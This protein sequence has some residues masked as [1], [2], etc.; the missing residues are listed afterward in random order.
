VDGLL[1][2]TAGTYES[3]FRLRYRAP[4]ILLGAEHYSTPVDIWSI[5]CIFAEMASSKPLFPGD[6][7][8]D[9]LFRIFRV[10]GTPNDHV[11]PGVSRLPN[12]KSEFPQWH[13]QRLER[14]VPELAPSDANGGP[15][16]CDLMAQMLTYAPAMRVTC[17]K[18][19]EHPFFQ[20]PRLD[21][22][23]FAAS[24]HALG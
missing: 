10:R 9:E 23:Q 6:S 2:E 24:T 22:L 16:A 14:A 8:I 21:K 17:R 7:E 3:D 5:G 4:E 18:A 11:W 13:P 20:P 12:Y 15:A 1:G 19:L